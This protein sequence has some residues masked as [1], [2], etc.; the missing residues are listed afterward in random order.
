[1]DRIFEEETFSIQG[2][3]RQYIFPNVRQTS[4]ASTHQKINITTTLQLN[5]LTHN[6]SHTS[7]PST[8]L[9]SFPMP[10]NPSCEGVF[11]FEKSACVMTAPRRIT[12]HLKP[13]GNPAHR[14]RACMCKY[15]DTLILYASILYD[16]IALF[17]LCLSP[18]RALVLSLPHH[19]SSCW[20]TDG[21]DPRSCSTLLPD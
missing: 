13:R 12:H 3:S 6:S 15:S 4:A 16:S 18:A 14:V 20:W 19:L 2:C 8:R 1:M 17:F 9:S 7:H 21:G 5:L 11:V 10:K